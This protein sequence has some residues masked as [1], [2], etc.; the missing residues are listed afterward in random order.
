MNR[1]ISLFQDV[2]LLQAPARPSTTAEYA[3]LSKP[4]CTSCGVGH[5]GDVNAV[6]ISSSFPLHYHSRSKALEPIKQNRML[7]R[8]L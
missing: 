6:Y 7:E 8:L 4:S 2:L 1:Q 3:C 5:D